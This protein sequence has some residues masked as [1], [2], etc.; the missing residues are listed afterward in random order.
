MSPPKNRHSVFGYTQFTGGENDDHN[1]QRSMSASSSSSSFDLLYSVHSTSDQEFETRRQQ[2]EKC[3]GPI[4]NQKLSY[5][6][7]MA[8]RFEEIAENN[9][10]NPACYR[11]PVRQKVPAWPPVAQ[12]VPEEDSED[13]SSELQLES[14]T[15]DENSIK[16]FEN[17]NAVEKTIEEIPSNAEELNLNAYPNGEQYEHIERLDSTSDIDDNEVIPVNESHFERSLGAQSDDEIEHNS[18]RSDIEAEW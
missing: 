3:C 7:R 4:R 12:T 6:Q 14:Q 10:D 11:A 15:I 18:I 17:F 2:R 16:S 5:V 9:C 1:R 8:K 13:E